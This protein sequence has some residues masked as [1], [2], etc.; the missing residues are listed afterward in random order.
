MCV[1]EISSRRLLTAVA[2]FRRH[3][4]GCG[5]RVSWVT[6]G[7]AG[8]EIEAG[9][10][11]VRVSVNCLANVLAQQSVAQARHAG[12]VRLRHGTC[13]TWSARIRTAVGLFYHYTCCGCAGL[14][15]VLAVIID[16]FVYFLPGCDTTCIYMISR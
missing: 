13:I 8:W 7:D 4:E 15:H 9:V 12:S 3:L 11:D 10:F 14:D 16:A 6:L 2:L 5:G 1:Y